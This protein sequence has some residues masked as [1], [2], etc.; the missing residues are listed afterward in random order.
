MQQ[1][2]ARPL[3]LVTT[4]VVPQ[5]VIV[6]PELLDSDVER[7]K[8]ATTDVDLVAAN[9]ERQRRLDAEARARRNRDDATARKPRFEP[10]TTITFEVA[11]KYAPSLRSLV[12]EISHEIGSRI[13]GS[14]SYAAEQALTDAAITVGALRAAVN[15]A[16]PV[17][18]AA[19]KWGKSAVSR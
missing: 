14:H 6:T 8:A 9:I 16:I 5:G 11:T 10:K 4:P 15:A 3:Q 18:D 19:W 2:A 7:L 12:E 1:T 13:E 17:G